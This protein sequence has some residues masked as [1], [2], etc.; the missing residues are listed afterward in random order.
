MWLLKTTKILFQCAPGPFVI[1]SQSVSNHAHIYLGAL[2]ITHSPQTLKG[3][4]CLH[5]KFMVKYADLEIDLFYAH[6]HKYI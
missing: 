4:I 1:Q 5:L 2:Q 3:L 6:G